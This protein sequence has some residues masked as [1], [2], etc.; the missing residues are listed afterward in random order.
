[1]SALIYL[2][3]L[4]MREGEADSDYSDSG[5][6]SILMIVS[7]VSVTISF[8]VHFFVTKRM[9]A[10]REGV[11]VMKA[12]PFFIISLALAESVAIYGLSLGL[13]GEDFTNCMPFFVISV[14]TLLLVAPVYLRHK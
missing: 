2:M 6:R 8:A 3:L 1:M 10:K 13:E 7:L 5:L 12:V 14:V 9:V 4:K 11:D